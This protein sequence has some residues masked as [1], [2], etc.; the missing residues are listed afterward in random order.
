MLSLL[1]DEQIS[2]VVAEQ[3]RQR[4]ADIPMESVRSWQGGAF[5]GADDAALL[6]AAHQVNLTLITYDRRTIPPLLLAWGASGETHAGVVFVDN[7]T[8]A[9][10]DIGGLVRAIIARWDEA[11]DWDWTNRVDFLRTAP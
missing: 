10:N 3:V 11:K 5:E 7:A 4:R 1:T 8:I 2:Y 6:R 9:H